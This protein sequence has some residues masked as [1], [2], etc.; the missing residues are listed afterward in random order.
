MLA[1]HGTQYGREE[2][3][4]Y[5]YQLEQFKPCEAKHKAMLVYGSIVQRGK[6]HLNRC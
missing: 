2:E 6:E 4:A 1:L 3:K 5:S